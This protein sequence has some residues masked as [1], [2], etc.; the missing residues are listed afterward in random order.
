M[1]TACPYAWCSDISLN[2]ED[3]VSEIWQ[4]SMKLG[5]VSCERI[6]LGHMGLCIE[7]T[8]MEDKD[9]DQENEKEDERDCVKCRVEGRRVLRQQH[10]A[11]DTWMTLEP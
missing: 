1:S 2:D 3:K 7:P 11:D 5:F 4:L 10:H 8:P 6:V 9:E